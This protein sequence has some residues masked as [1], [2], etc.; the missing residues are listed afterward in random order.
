MAAS[1]VVR[2]RILWSD[3]DASGKYHNTAPLRLM[4]EAEAVL[5]DRLGIV[6]DVY[7]RLPRVHATIDYRRPLRFWEE[8]ETTVEVAEVGTAS[9]TYRFA[10]RD[11]SGQICAQGQVVA[12]LVDDEVQPRAWSDEQRRLLLGP[13]EPPSASPPDSGGVDTA[14]G[15]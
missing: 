6:R 5:L 14:S 8:A 4:E 13:G 12:V 11:D 1:A 2:R 3:T 9:V 7:G 10:I 15:S